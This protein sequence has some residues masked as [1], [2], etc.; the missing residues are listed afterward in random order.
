MKI[1]RSPDRRRSE[2]P[3][4]FFN[5]WRRL[6]IWWSIQLS[7]GI[8]SNTL[9]AVRITSRAGALMS[10][11]RIIY[12]LGLAVIAAVTWFLLVPTTRTTYEGLFTPSLP[13][14]QAHFA[15]GAWP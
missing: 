5:Q 11:A 10:R 1:E 6:S 13:S 3:L 8:F 14:E 15:C 12:L 4:F 7:D 2:P 9:C